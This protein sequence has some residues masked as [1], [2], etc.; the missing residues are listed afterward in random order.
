MT[1]LKHSKI[2]LLEL[3]KPSQKTYAAAVFHLKHLE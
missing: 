3:N 1:K 2:S